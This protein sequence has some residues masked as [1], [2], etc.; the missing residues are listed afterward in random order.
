MA[1]PV[2][3]DERIGGVMS[4]TRL[5]A[6][7]A[8]ARGIADPGEEPLLAALDPSLWQVAPTSAGPVLALVGHLHLHAA[9]LAGL[10]VARLSPT[11]AKTLLAVLIATWTGEAHP[12]PGAVAN[13]DDVLNVL[14]GRGMGLQAAAHAKGALNKLRTWRLAQLGPA[15]REE[16]VTADLG[17]L[18]RVGPAV[19]LWSGPWV[20]ELMTLV[21]HLAEHR[22][23]R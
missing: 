23:P 11:Q 5:A 1:R 4:D 16:V 20:S 13:V 6:A 3:A 10:P 8:S 12:Y 17:V 18:V 7:R 9:D 2:R 15:G 19:S 22:R 14:G 21:G